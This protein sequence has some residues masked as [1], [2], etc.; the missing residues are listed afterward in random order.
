M[1]RQRVKPADVL[2]D[3]LRGARAQGRTAA[4]LIETGAL[5][6]INENTLRVTLSRLQARGTIES[7]ERGRYRLTTTADPINEFVDRWR[8]GESRVKPWDGRWLFV[9]LAEPSNRSRWAL[10]ALGFRLLRPGLS[11]RPANLNLDREQLKRL[12]C[13]IGL[14]ASALLIEGETDSEDGAWRAL[15]ACDEISDEYRSMTRRLKES[16]AQLDAMDQEAARIETFQLGGEAIH[17]L[18]KDPLLPSE[19]VDTE[20][21]EALWR[22]LRD[23]DVAGQRIWATSKKDQS[24]SLPI[25]RLANEA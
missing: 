13:S 5:F 10:D 21:R 2:L 19:F 6:G 7:P 11:V 18:A 12:M 20:A 3:L 25:P 16:A 23:Y 8:L 1:S 17:L 22:T 9:H 4:Y 15:W 24:S 14:P